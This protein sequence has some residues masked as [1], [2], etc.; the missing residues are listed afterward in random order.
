[1]VS[2]GPPGADRRC[3]QDVWHQAGV[4]F[5][6]PM[7]LH[8]LKLLQCKPCIGNI[9]V[10][11]WVCREGCQ[12]QTCD[13]HEWCGSDSQLRGVMSVSWMAYILVYNRK[14]SAV[15]RTHAQGCLRMQALHWGRRM[16]V[17][18]QKGLPRSE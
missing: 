15:L 7:G 6:G 18:K 3:L 4:G 1:M 17:D 13:M 16:D 2:R 12:M 9:W 14:M 10:E 5:D 11:M 8:R